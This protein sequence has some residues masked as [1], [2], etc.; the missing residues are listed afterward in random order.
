MQKTTVERAARWESTAQR[1]PASRHHRDRRLETPEV[2][3]TCWSAV[4]EY[5]IKPRSSISNR[6]ERWMSRSCRMNSED[7]ARQTRQ[8]RLI[9]DFRAGEENHFCRG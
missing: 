4:T 7:K 5:N 8:T 9:N 2:E 1:R 3:K 6:D